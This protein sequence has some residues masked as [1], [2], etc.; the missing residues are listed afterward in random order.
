MTALIPRDLPPLRLPVVTCDFC[1]SDVDTEDALFDSPDA[2]SWKEITGKIHCPE[3]WVTCTS[4]GEPT[5]WLWAACVS[6]Y[7][8]HC[9]DCGD[10]CRA[11]GL[12]ES[13]EREPHDDY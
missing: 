8:Y 9:R 5:S 4:C 12:W 7:D 2:D 13:Q 1:D 11:C 3:H 6:D 10:T